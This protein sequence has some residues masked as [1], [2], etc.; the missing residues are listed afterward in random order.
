MKI[1]LYQ[2]FNAKKALDRLF[3]S[4]MSP[5]LAYRVADLIEAVN[6]EL[7]KIEKVRVKL[8][9]ENLEEGERQVVKNLETFSKAFDEFLDEE[10]ELEYEPE[11]SI[12]D[13]PDTVE[14]SP[15]EMHLIRP[16]LAE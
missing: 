9:K 5:R 6:P 7:E 15:K 3:N 10:I 4:E 11:I 8:V 1:F 14:V 12:D 2:I 13:L 16:F